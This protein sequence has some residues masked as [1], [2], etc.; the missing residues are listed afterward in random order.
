MRNPPFKIKPGVQYY[1]PTISHEWQDEDVLTSVTHML[2]EI[3]LCV[4]CTPEDDDAKWDQA[5][6]E[7]RANQ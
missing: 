1:G 4:I 5:Y 3:L 6:E 7:Y 2:N